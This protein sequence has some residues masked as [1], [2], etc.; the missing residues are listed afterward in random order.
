VKKPLWKCG[1]ERWRY[2]A[3]AEWRWRIVDAVEV[4]P[5]KAVKREVA[6]SSSGDVVG[7][8]G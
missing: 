6:E 7:S 5:V 4:K 3:F 1:I 2:G 8:A